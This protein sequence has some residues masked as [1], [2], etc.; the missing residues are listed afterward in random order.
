MYIE[1]MDSFIF[2]LYGF[3]LGK[4]TSNN[5][6]IHFY[7]CHNHV[8]GVTLKMS[9]PNT[10]LPILIQLFEGAPPSQLFWS[11]SATPQTIPILSYWKKILVLTEYNILQIPGLIIP[12]LNVFLWEGLCEISLPG[13]A[14][15]LYPR[16]ILISLYSPM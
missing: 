16:L 2:V 6:Y 13:W 10:P 5:Y 7:L 3:L 1:D 9:L 11:S 14:V 4:F 15:I 8:G 12:C